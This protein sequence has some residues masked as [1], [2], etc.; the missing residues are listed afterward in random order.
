MQRI[1]RK[2]LEGAVNLLNRITG[3]EPEPYRKENDK[4]VANIGNFHISG[5]YGG[6]SLHQMVN[7][8]GGVRD[9]FYCGHIPCVTFM[10]AYTPSDTVLSLP[11]SK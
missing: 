11:V 10:T 4:W 9:V 3:N 2:D 6:V 1:T 5:A 8:G 7:E